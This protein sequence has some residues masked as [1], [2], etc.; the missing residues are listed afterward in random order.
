MQ[1]L[2]ATRLEF[3]GLYYSIMHFRIYLEGVTSFVVRTDC[4]NLLNLATIFQNENS[5]M[6]RRLSHLQTFKFKIEHISGTS[7]E[8]KLADYLSRYPAEIQT[9]AP[10]KFLQRRREAVFHSAAAAYRRLEPIFWQ[11][12]HCTTD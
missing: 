4:K 9:W 1:K 11:H 8:I 12:S 10:P 6:Q 2:G 3:L 7:E 5:Y